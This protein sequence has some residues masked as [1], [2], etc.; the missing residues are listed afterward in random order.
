MVAPKKII[1]VYGK[2]Q[3]TYVIN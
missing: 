1:A 2:E 3:P